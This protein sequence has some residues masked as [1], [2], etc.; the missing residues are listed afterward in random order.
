MVRS[1]EGF[2]TGKV[3]EVVE[4]EMQQLSSLVV[5]DQTVLTEYTCIIWMRN[6]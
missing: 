5:S 3:C 4:M 6:N 1:G 2:Q